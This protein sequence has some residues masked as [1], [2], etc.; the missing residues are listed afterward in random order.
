[1]SKFRVEHRAQRP[2][3]LGV[4]SESEALVDGFAL[5]LRAENKAPRTVE[6]TPNPSPSS[7]SG[8]RRT[9]APR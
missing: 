6:T 8:S 2:I 5:S 7:P 3:I 4:N 9:T 1:M